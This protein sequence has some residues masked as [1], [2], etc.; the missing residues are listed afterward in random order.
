[1]GRVCHTH[2]S[3]NCLLTIRYIGAHMH[4]EQVAPRSCYL[5]NGDDIKN[6]NK[7]IGTHCAQTGLFIW[8]YHVYKAIDLFSVIQTHKRFKIMLFLV[9]KR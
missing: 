7:G 3:D 6:K 4:D 1:M 9:L 5:L 2:S 8:P